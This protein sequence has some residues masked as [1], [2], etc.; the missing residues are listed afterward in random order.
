MSTGEHVS[1]ASF[2]K[3]LIEVVYQ[4]FEKDL[5][6]P[7]YQTLKSF[8]NS[9]LIVNARNFEETNP[10]NVIRIDRSRIATQI[11][12]MNTSLNGQTIPDIEYQLSNYLSVIEQKLDALKRNHEPKETFLDRYGAMTYL[13][14]IFLM[15]SVL[16]SFLKITWEVQSE[17]GRVNEDM[18]RQK[19]EELNAKDKFIVRQAAVNKT[20]LLSK[21]RELEQINIS[22]QDAERRL[23]ELQRRGLAASQEAQDLKADIAQM[24]KAALIHKAKIMDMTRQLEEKNAL[25]QQKNANAKRGQDAVDDLFRE[26]GMCSG[27][28]FDQVCPAK[29]NVTQGQLQKLKE[30]VKARIEN[31]DGVN[32]GFQKENLQLQQENARLKAF[33]DAYNKINELFP[34]FVQVS[35]D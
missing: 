23:G 10:A 8:L 21:Q 24:Q 5:R 15:V 19:Q 33:E 25:I 29:V 7:R 30:Q 18:V 11:R 13:M 20:E 1:L 12:N 4:T 14:K 6:D 34:R 3:E 32:D 16:V 27:L 26:L 17:I 28:N 31:C 9:I 35:I 22:L 2:T